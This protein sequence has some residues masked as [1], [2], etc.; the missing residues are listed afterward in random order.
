MTKVIYLTKI[1]LYL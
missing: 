1:G